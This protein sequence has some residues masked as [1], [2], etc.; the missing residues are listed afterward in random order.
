MAIKIFEKFAPRANPADGDYPYGSIK[1]ESVPGA[2]DGTP[3][4]AEWGNDY[5]GFDAELFAQAGVVP[6]GA[7]D[8]LGAS[9]RVD[10]IRVITT[11]DRKAASS[12][13]NYFT[14]EQETFYTLNPNR[15]IFG[16]EYLWGFH[17]QVLDSSNT[18]TSKFIW[19]GD[20]T[21][22]GSNVGTYTPNYIGQIVCGKLGLAKSTHINS[23]HSGEA[24][25]DWVDTYV[26][27]DIA[28]H[29][30]MNVYV[31]R[32]GINDGSAHGDVAT[33]I[34]AMDGGLTKLRAF[35]GVEALTIVVVSPNS[36]YDN[37]NNRGTAWYEAAIPE[38]RKLCRKHMATFI[39]IYS[40]WQD[41][42][43]GALPGVPRWMD[44]PYGD[45]R[46]IHPDA[47]LALQIGVRVTEMIVAPVMWGQG[48]ATNQFTSS[49]PDSFR[50]SEAVP[51][52]GYGR[53]ISLWTVRVSDGW[54]LNGKLKVWRNGTKVIQELHAT[55]DDGTADIKL[56]SPRATR[57]GDATSGTFTTWYGLPTTPLLLNSWAV[58][59]GRTPKYT[60]KDSG[61]CSLMGTVEGG[62]DGEVIF[63]LPAAMRP[64]A[65][66]TFTVAASVGNGTIVVMD[67]GDVIPY[68][69]AGTF[70]NLDGVVWS[71]GD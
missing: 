64:S 49:D 35:K 37:P 62:A 6:S 59:A 5:A 32:W 11:K 10:A 3:L 56:A 7:P 55:S 45:G 54:P 47:A 67:N 57:Y 40:I 31:T 28:A 25:T 14:V 66:R 39:D 34:A 24:A 27:A 12:N 65:P 20:S 23:G 38:L 70:V 13:S 71:A 33:Y 53:G 4:D 63:N 50:P 18:N 19:S 21:T 41:A 44:D 26:D 9:Q 8:K 43:Q 29:S 48:F 69:N 1:N 17:K 46:G 15:H 2:K 16:E 52:S 51:P 58:T 30:D 60:H 22:A 36:T 61:L 68:K 42:R